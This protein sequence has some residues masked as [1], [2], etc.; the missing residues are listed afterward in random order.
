MHISTLMWRRALPGAM[1]AALIAAWATPALA[2]KPHHHRG[3]YTQSSWDGACKVERK[4][5]RNGQ[6]KEKRKC[7][8][9]YVYPHAVYPQP[10]YGTP[11]I[12]IQ[13]PAIVIRP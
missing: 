10:A 13:P 4:W 6:Y 9:A 12:V 3:D 5:K 11:S 7:R 8:P 2:H 1:M